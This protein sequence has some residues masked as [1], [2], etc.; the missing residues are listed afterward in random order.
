MLPRCQYRS[1]C[2]LSMF[3]ARPI[4]PCQAVQSIIR[5]PGHSPEV[6]PCCESVAGTPQRDTSH[7][8]SPHFDIRAQCMSDMST[9]GINSLLAADPVTVAALA[10]LILPGDI[11]AKLTHRAGLARFPVG[12]SA[13]ITLGLFAKAR[14]IATRCSSPPEGSEG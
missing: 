14:A 10:A 8:P 12:S 2:L 11:W 13:S 5:S 4:F 7:V 1:R 6:L 3:P 9:Y